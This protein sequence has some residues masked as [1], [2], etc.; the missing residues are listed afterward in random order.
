MKKALLALTL[1]ALIVVAGCGKKPSNE[2]PK[3]VT[4]YQE[5]NLTA[6]QNKKLADIRATQKQ[7]MDA[8]RKELD[9][10]RAILVDTDGSKK[11]TEAQK[12][13]NSAKYR[14][15]ASQM[16]DKLSIERK[17]YDNAF[18]GILDDK[19]KKTYQRYL[20]EREKEKLAREEAFKKGK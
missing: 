17:A 3:S 9:D 15:A 4:I 8:I 19:Q 1:C 12:R 20:E 18:M 14:A 13:E 5:L 11:F 2:I 16:R 7:K 10:Q 6:E